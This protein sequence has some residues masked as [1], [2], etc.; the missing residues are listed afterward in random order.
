M[1]NQYDIPLGPMSE[2]ELCNI[3]NTNGPDM[4]KEYKD[5]LDSYDWVDRP[6]IDY[7]VWCIK[8]LKNIKLKEIL[9]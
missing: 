5:E 4:Y 7:Y 9:Q 3:L 1:K 8:K 2:I 6:R